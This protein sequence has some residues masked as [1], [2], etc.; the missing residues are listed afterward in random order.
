MR[1]LYRRSSQVVW[2]KPF[3]LFELVQRCGVW[4]WADVHCEEEI[5]GVSWSP[6]SRYK[7]TVPTRFQ[8]KEKDA[9]FLYDINWFTQAVSH[10]LLLWFWQK[11]D[12]KSN[13]FTSFALSNQSYKMLAVAWWVHL[14]VCVVAC[15]R[16]NCGDV[17][18]IPQ[19]T[20]TI[21][22][23]FNPNCFSCLPD[24]FMNLKTRP[25]SVFTRLLTGRKR[26]HERHGPPGR[27]QLVCHMR[28]QGDGQTLRGLQLWRLQGLLQT[29]R[30]Q[31]PHV[32]VQVRAEQLRNSPNDSVVLA[33]PQ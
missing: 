29:Q 25:S 17:I 26:Q 27:R 12:G 2:S 18:K 6:F 4:L 16:G 13:F 20:Q 19:S 23:F 11:P 10:D 28:R 21:H 22:T 33:Q 3:D 30:P 15:D 8:L 14:N 24:W 7:R 32:L 9:A 31:K 1:R 5:A